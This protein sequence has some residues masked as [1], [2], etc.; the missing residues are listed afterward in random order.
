MGDHRSILTIGC[1]DVFHRHVGKEGDDIRDGGLPGNAWMAPDI[2][3]QSIQV[4]AGGMVPKVKYI[5]PV[6]KVLASSMEVR[7]ELGLLALRH[8]GSIVKSLAQDVAE[9]VLQKRRVLWR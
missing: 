5:N 2:G 8:Q 7:E 9:Q 4:H 1:E 3:Y 6:R